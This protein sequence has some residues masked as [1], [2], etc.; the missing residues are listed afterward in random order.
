MCD[1]DDLRLVPGGDVPEQDVHLPLPEDFEMGVRLVDQK[2]RVPVG[3]EIG[4]DQ[5]QLLQP[6]PGG[7][8]FK[9]R[10][11]VGLTV[12][13]IDTAARRRSWS[14]Q[15]N[16]EQ[17]LHQLDDLLP[18]A[19]G[20]LKDQQTQIAQYLGG[21]TLPQQHV[22][23]AGLDDGFFGLQARHRI[24]QMHV[25]RGR[26]PDDAESLQSRLVRRAIDQ[27]LAL[28]AKPHGHRLHR[29][30]ML[31]ADRDQDRNV[32]IAGPNRGVVPEVAGTLNRN[33]DDVQPVEGGG[34]PFLGPGLPLRLEPGLDRLR[35][36]RDR[37]DRRRLAAVVGPDQHR[38][39]IELDAL[40]VAEVLEVPDLQVVQQSHSRCLPPP[41][42]SIAARRPR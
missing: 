2:H 26:G 28:I 42:A 6:A 14:S 1:Q 37:L 41:A 15:R 10:L 13:Q 19:S 23:A 32:A 3:V 29:I 31:H 7:G 30:P 20:V 4:E 8:Y 18:V 11:H 38:R 12:E 36:Q 27:V 9:R 17:P 21:L 33:G 39:M 22:D 24:E 5:E 34:G 16:G 40:Q 25:Q 35:P